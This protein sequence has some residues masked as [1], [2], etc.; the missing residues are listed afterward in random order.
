M[1]HRT[2][3]GKRRSLRRACL[4]RPPDKVEALRS[5][6]D[7]GEDR[8]GEEVPWER[9]EPVRVVEVED[10]RHEKRSVLPRPRYARRS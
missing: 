8:P 5:R 1:A 10:Q 3:H 4:G 9:R 7:V 6:I 2:Q